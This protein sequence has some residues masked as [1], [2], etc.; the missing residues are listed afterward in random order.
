LL[1][2]IAG[3]SMNKDEF[4]K[5]WKSVEIIKTGEESNI[6]KNVCSKLL[7][8]TDKIGLDKALIK[9]DDKIYRMAY[10][11]EEADKLGIEY[12]DY[13]TVDYTAIKYPCYLLFADNWVG[14]LFGI[15]NITFKIMVITGIDE[16]ICMIKNK[17]TN[18]YTSNLDIYLDLNNKPAE[19]VNSSNDV[20]LTKK[21]IIAHLLASG[22]NTD[23]ITQYF[24]NDPALSR[25][26]QVNR[27]IN[28]K[29]TREMATK[30]VK[31]ALADKGLDPSLIIDWAIEAKNMC[32]RNNNP[33]A[34][35]DLIRETAE[36]AG[37]HDKDTETKTDTVELI[38]YHKD[39]LTLNETK[40]TVKLKKEETK[41]LE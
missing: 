38:D 4:L 13:R 16:R 19:L 25:R 6:V 34:F 21:V 17:L 26:R 31:E 36:W 39:M 9:F 3:V 35:V 32:T 10:S 12:H 5:K 2:D 41:E 27:I 28:T 14:A 7:T 8:V 30:I 29:G 18:T 11:V 22:C 23:Q 24:A 20:P 40:Q 15:F 37:F 1:K 33:K